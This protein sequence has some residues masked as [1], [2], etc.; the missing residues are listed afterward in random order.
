MV[1]STLCGLL[2]LAIVDGLGQYQPDLSQD[3][4]SEALL[5]QY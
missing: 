3:T 4:I 1:F 2:F 5:V